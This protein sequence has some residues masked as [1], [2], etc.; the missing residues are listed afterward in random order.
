[1]ALESRLRISYNSVNERGIGLSKDAW[2]YLRKPRIIFFALFFLGAWIRS[3]DVWRP[4]DGR[5]RESWREC[6]YAAVARNFYREGMNI[7]YPRIDWH[8]DGP[9]YAE[10]EF[11]VIP[12]TTAALYKIFGYHEV[13][14]RILVYAFSLLTLLIFFLLARRLTI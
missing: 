1:M 13:I 3:L 5:V 6:D 2:G 10:M 4:V 14:G 11:P 7:L 8:G 9:G 12:W